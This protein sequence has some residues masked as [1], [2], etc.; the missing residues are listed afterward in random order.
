MVIVIIKK[1][2]TFRMKWGTG[3]EME[4]ERSL[5][6][7]LSLLFFANPERERLLII[8]FTVLLAAA[9]VASLIAGVTWKIKFLKVKN[10]RTKEVWKPS[11]VWF[12]I[13]MIFLFIAL[14]IYLRFLNPF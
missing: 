13:A 4:V 3:G 5:I 2:V 8:L 9:L 11:L 1:L 7:L 6:F 14:I 12:I 10:V